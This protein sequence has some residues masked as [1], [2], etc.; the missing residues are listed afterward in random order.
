[1]AVPAAQRG[2]RF[3][4]LPAGV[5]P[6]DRGAP[7]WDHLLTG[8][9]ATPYVFSDD[10]LVVLPQRAAGLRPA[11][12][13]ATDQT[14]FGLLAVTGMRIGEA[15]ALDDDDIDLD[16]AVVAV[17]H[18]K[19]GKSRELMV[20]PS[21]VRHEHYR[22]S[23]RHHARRQAGPCS[24]L[25]G[26]PAALLQR[27]RRVPQPD[28]PHGPNSRDTRWPASPHARP[29]PPIRDR[30][31]ARMVSTGRRRPDPPA[32]AVHLP[33]ARPSPG[34]V[35]VLVRHPSTARTGRQA[36]RQRL[37]VPDMSLLAPPRS[38]LRRT[39]GRSAPGQPPHHRLIP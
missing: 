11:L 10:E 23:R 36:S 35:L 29:A 39:P 14:L 19:W 22:R 1:M 13:A 8:S 27:L 15:I 33:R 4:S 6:P 34:H 38:V 3:R 9:D 31:P 28:E 30:D 25:S 17:R 37:G 16:D 32:T 18:G 24:C 12:R 7:S 5:R 2:T 21:T 26:K 20:H